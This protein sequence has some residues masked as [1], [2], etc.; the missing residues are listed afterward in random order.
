MNAETENQAASNA[1]DLVYGLGATGLS[2]ARYLKRRGKQ[3][4]Y[5]DTRAAPPGMAELSEICAD[6][7]MIFGETPKSLLENTARV[8]VSPGIADTDAYLETARA[9]NVEVVSDIELFVGEAVAPF[10]AITGSNG[11]S[12]VTTLL[13]L[14]CDAA[15]KTAYAGA[16]LGVPAL[17]LLPREKPDFYLL[18]LSSFQLHRTRNLP[19]RVAV[20]L[21]IS[22]DHLD[23]HASEDEYRAA[24]YRVFAQAESA[25]FNRADDA[26]AERIPRNVRTVSFGLDRP[27][28]DQFGLL[29]DGGVLFLARGEQ[30]LLA[31]A[32]VA[33][34]GTHN[35]A[36]ALAA[37]ATG[38]LMGLDMSAMLQ[39]LN[40]FPGLPHRMQSVAKIDGVH[41][42][43]DSKATNVGAAIASVES[44]D[45]SVILIAGGQGKGGDFD[46]LATSTGSQLRSVVLLGEDAALLQAAFVDLVQISLAEDMRS[47]VDRAAAIAQPGDTVLFAPAC[48]SF[49]MYQN[50]QARGDDFC[51][52][53]E[54]LSQ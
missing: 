11:K 54:A 32:D 23:W 10:I 49:D 1:Q 9:G 46:M 38:E 53:V 21:N 12:T 4:K 42:I 36:N 41:Y 40:E 25:V 5:V 22:P 7:V 2:V 26:A 27:R 3:A 15:G 24:K 52:K 50:Y 39:V 17:D 29:E 45:G 14:M 44:I 8:I 6:A 35:L 43:N 33:M 31:T 34:V 20:L 48:A 51:A 37:L 47:A 30:L 28:P 18:E 19:A 16:N 13:A